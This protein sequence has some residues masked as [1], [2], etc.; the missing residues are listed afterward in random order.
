MLTRRI[1]K[2]SASFAVGPPRCDNSARPNLF[3]RLAHI[4]KLHCG[5]PGCRLN[6]LVPEEL[7]SGLEVGFFRHESA[8][9]MPQVVETDVLRRPVS[10]PETH[11]LSSGIPFIEESPYRERVTV[12]FLP[13]PRGIVPPRQ[14]CEYIDWVFPILRREDCSNIR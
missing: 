2:F 11:R 14:I 9:S 6:P 12:S 3:H 8:S 1:P 7:L 4:L 13:T 5:I 10:E